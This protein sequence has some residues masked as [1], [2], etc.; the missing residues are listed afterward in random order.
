MCLSSSLVHHFVLIILFTSTT[1]LNG[2]AGIAL[3]V[4]WPLTSQSHGSFL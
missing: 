2:M 1:L 3:H 4:Q